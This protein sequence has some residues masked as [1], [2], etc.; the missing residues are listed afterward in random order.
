MSSNALINIQTESILFIEVNEFIN[1]KGQNELALFFGL[2]DE[3][4]IIDNIFQNN[5]N[6][7][8][9][10]KK[11]FFDFYDDDKDKPLED[12]ILIDCF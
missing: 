6:I 3:V 12:R 9:E 5:T 8:C 7:A 1:N 10:E 4:E 2:D 11:R